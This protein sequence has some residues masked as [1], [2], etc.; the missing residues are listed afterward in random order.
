MGKVSVSIIIVNWNGIAH[1]KPLFESIEKLDFDK[2]KLEVIMVDNASSDDSVKFIEGNFKQAKVLKLDKNYGF[3]VG[4]NR[5]IEQAKGDYILLL[6]NDT[7][8]DKNL[9]FALL[10]GFEKHKTAGAVGGKVYEWNEENPAFGT[11]N[12]ISSSWPK[13]RPFTAKPFNFTDE[14]DDHP[15]DYLP[16]CMMMVKKEVI[17]KVGLL[18][19]SYDAYFEETDLCARI[20]RAGYDL[21]YLK[22]AMIWHR[23]AA[24]SKTI[25]RDFNHKMMARNRVR[26]VLK[27]FDLAYLL[28]FAIYYPLEVIFKFLRL[29]YLILKSVFSSPGKRGYLVL[30]IAYYAADLKFVFHSIIW[31]LMNLPQTVQARFRDLG[32]IKNRRSYN[33]NL[34]LSGVM[35]N[36]RDL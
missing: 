27:N 2:K 13:I 15:V 19:E 3:C 20:I 34:P 30:V 5:G 22:D 8:V 36:R 32:K 9:L 7:V 24:S 4:N 12:K 26:F 23:V 25:S 16:G 14:Q 29:N 17:E 28:F 35:P 31:N 6:N 1:L 33:R 21:I 10:K 18:D 11:K